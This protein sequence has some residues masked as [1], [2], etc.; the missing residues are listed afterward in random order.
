MKDAGLLPNR[1]APDDD[2]DDDNVLV[3]AAVDFVT[4]RL[5]DFDFTALTD[6]VKPL[7]WVVAIVGVLARPL[8]LLSLRVVVANS[9]TGRGRAEKEEDLKNL[10]EEDDDDVG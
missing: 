8:F 6:V 9:P 4:F 2:D 5:G 10:E 7:V 1:D 3:V